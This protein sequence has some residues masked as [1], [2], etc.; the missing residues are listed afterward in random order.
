LD[1]QGKEKQMTT[2]I[3]SGTGEVAGYI[4]NDIKIVRS[5]VKAR[6]RRTSER[7]W[8]IAKRDILGLDHN[9]YGI[10]FFTFRTLAEAKDFIESK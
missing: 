10:H 1:Y 5:V 9:S 7:T 8:K 3:L 4:H 6:T 2:K